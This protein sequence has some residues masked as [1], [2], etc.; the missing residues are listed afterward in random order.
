MAR[1]ETPRMIFWVGWLMLNLD[2]LGITMSLMRN[3]RIHQSVHTRY[4]GL[5]SVVADFAHYFYRVKLDWRNPIEVYFL[6]VYWAQKGF[7]TIL[8]GLLSSQ[9]EY[10]PHDT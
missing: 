10:Q 5:S 6:L 9:R 3:G 7:Q 4:F 8:V 1:S 2:K